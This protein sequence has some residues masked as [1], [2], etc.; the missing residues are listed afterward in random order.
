ML[1]LLLSATHS[2]LYVF[3]VSTGMGESRGSGG[4]LGGWR[5]AGVLV[6]RGLLERSPKAPLWWDFLLAMPQG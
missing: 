4:S 5:V 3:L 6:M 2:G 1:F